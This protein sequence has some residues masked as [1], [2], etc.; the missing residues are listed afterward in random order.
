MDKK[1]PCRV[2]G[3]C[4]KSTRP[5][6]WGVGISCGEKYPTII[7]I[8]LA[9]K[10][11]F[12]CPYEFPRQGNFCHYEFPRQKNFCHYEFPTNPQTNPQRFSHRPATC[13]LLL[14]SELS[15]HLPRQHYSFCSH[16]LLR[17]PQGCRALRVRS[18]GS[19]AI[20]HASQE[21]N[22]CRHSGSQCSGQGGGASPPWISR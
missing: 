9:Q 20:H 13:L 4:Q 14:S 18:Q 22:L 12:F 16:R 8:F 1:V 17:R 5:G 10:R 19:R 11:L 7:A 15:S 3:L 21:A 6:A 2:A